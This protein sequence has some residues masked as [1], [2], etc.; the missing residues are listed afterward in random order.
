MKRSVLACLAGVVA[1]VVV[2]SLINRGLRITLA[3]YSVA[4]HSEQYT[5]G[6][7]WARLSMACVASMSAGAAAR[8]VARAGRWEAWVV[9]CIA[10]AIFVPLHI[11]IW[12]RF[13]AWYHLTFLLS[14]LPAVLLGARL[15]GRPSPS[16]PGE[17][18]R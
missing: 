13:P 5:L 14:T 11:S 7:K 10:L 8:G 12:S 6:M 1:W 15:A 17:A 16:T 4:E 3:G 18:G 9:G 2:A